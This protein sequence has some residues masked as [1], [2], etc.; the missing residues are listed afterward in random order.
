VAVFDFGIKHNI[1]RCLES[2]G[3][4]VV[5]IPGTTDADTVRAMAPDG[6]LLSNGPGDPEA[7]VFAVKTI[8]VLIDFRPM[9][10]ICLGHQL[11][12]LALDGRTYKLKFGHRGGNQPVKNLI[13]GKVE[14][15]SQNHG[16]AVDSDSL[17]PQSI[18][19]THI[20]LN[21]GT[22]EGFRHRHLPLLAVQYHPEAAP[23]P[24]DAGHLFSEFRIMVADFHERG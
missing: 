15:T 24:R 23:G 1:L 9:F 12:S 10:G 19:I 7:A 3:F 18:E 20:N 17:N 14:I 4:E 22:V 5:V 6:I 13:T 21:D 11:M 8:G 16:F 2:E